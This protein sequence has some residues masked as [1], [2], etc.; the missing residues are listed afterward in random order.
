MKRGF[1]NKYLYIFISIVLSLLLHLMMLILMMKVAVFP[2]LI[3][4]PKKYNRTM[5]IVHM[6]IPKKKKSPEPAHT[7]ILPDTPSEIADKM[8]TTLPDSTGNS[9]TET[10]YDIPIPDKSPISN[11]SPTLPSIVSV[12]ADTLSPERKEF[13]RTL[14]PKLPRM[15]GGDYR[16]SSSGKVGENSEPINLRVTL[17]PLKKLPETLPTTPATRLITE[18]QVVS[19]DPLIDVRLYKYPLPTGAGFFRIDLSPNKKAAVLKN[20]NKDVIVL[21]D[22][23][24]SI[25]RRRLAEFKDGVQ[26]ALYALNPNDRINIVAFK[27]KN[28]PMSK[29]LLP[30]TPK[31]IKRAEMFI[32]RLDYGGTTNIYSALE[33]FVGQKNR[34]AARPLIIFLLSDGQVNAGDVIGS[35]DLI[36]TISNQN[37]N[38][39][40]IYTYSCGEDRNS[41]LMD[42]LSYR[43]RGESLNIPEIRDSNKKLTTFID[44]VS[45]VKVAD[46]EYQISSD[47]A[48]ATFPKRLPNLYKNKTLSIYGRY[49]REDEAIGL[50][51]TGRDSLGLRREIVVGGTIA[52]ATTVDYRLAQEWAKQYIYHLYSLLSVKYSVKIK[53]EIHDVAARY[54]LELPFLDKHLVPRKENFVR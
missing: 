37:S 27:S 52:D 31:N 49:G 54:R 3:Q 12:D 19:M 51:I 16:F 11:E 48:D 14:I 32:F 17:P 38:G 8:P 50:R 6:P 35:R 28:Y 40:A 13:N 15:I 23:S 20:F 25:G 39:A 26:N 24:G 18:E 44:A 1:K 29:L 4:E 41:F 7:S 22:V 46:L 2:S 45:D 21:M 43:N 5:K 47:L 30:A 53:N 33:P 36:N 42:I 9:G 10:K 34:V